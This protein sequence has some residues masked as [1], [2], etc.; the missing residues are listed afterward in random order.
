[1]S[2]RFEI[3][4]DIPDIAI[5]EMKEKADG[6]HI[7][8]ESTIRHTKCRC[9]GRVITKTYGHDRERVIRHLPILGKPTYLHIRPLRFRCDR[10]S[11]HPTTTQTLAW[12]ERG[13][14]YT[15]AYEDRL[16]LELVH[17]SVTDVALKEAVGYESL[18]GV[19]DRRVSTQ[20]DWKRFEHL[21]V[22]GIDE[23]ALK[24]GHG[25]FITLISTREGDK[26]RLLG[27]LK[28]REK[29]TVKAFFSSIPKRLRKTI[30]VVCS[31]LYSGFIH[32]ANEVFG[33]RVRVVAD[34]FHVAK[35]Y[36]Q[37]V[38]EL[39]KKELRR[40]KKEL[41]EPEYQELKGALWAVRRRVDQRTAE[42][43][44]ILAKLFRHSPALE[45]AYY[46]SGLLTKVF[47]SPI[48]RRCARYRIKKWMAL[49]RG[50]GLDCF[51]RFL[52]TVATWQEEILNYFI[53]R[54][55]SGFVEGL[56]NKIK[57]LKRRC[58]GILN[59]DHLFQRLYLDLGEY[60]ANLDAPAGQ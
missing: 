12:Y 8:I 37:G 32:A 2:Q 19:L 26:T 49:V 9:C 27:V 59:L 54:H 29:A 34:R 16:L 57:V 10:C 38:D 14:E 39:R 42:D 41:T 44:R 28:G 60:H 24:K 55:S 31:D 21:G 1:M 56:N 43:E 46:L 33:R 35:L 52:K 22:I 13:S 47:E 48:S 45:T 4:L 15:R 3:T 23:I 20:V 58:Y 53:D 17:S 40:L 18:M 7:H 51:N 50:S 36:R 6:I 25:D 30:A 5:V 11:G